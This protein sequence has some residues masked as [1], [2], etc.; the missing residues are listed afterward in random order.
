MPEPELQIF[1]D[2]KN[3][4]RMREQAQEAYTVAMVEAFKQNITNVQIARVLGIS[5][6][7]VRMWRRR[8]RELLK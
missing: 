5:E 7:A 4:R 1:N 2:L 6:T 3:A 8:H